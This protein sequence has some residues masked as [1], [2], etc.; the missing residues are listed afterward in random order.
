[1]KI[2]LQV[3]STS[4]GIGGSICSGM[5]GSTSSG[6]YKTKD[7]TKHEYKQV[8]YKAIIVLM[9]A[10]LDFQKNKSSILEHRSFNDKT[11]L[12]NEL[13]AE[14]SC[15]TLYASDAVILAM[16]EFVQT[17]DTDNFIK[18]TLEMRRDLYNISTKLVPTNLKLK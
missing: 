17:P 11:D 1:M 3:G 4:S 6:I 2:N 8:R 10:A 15:M 16:K 13:H 7:Q 18:T 5:R 12:L 9:Y 14:W